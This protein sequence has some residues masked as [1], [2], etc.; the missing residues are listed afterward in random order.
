MKLFRI[1]TNILF[2]FSLLFILQACGSGGG[3]STSGSLTLAV[4]KSKVNCGDVVVATVTLASSISTMPVNG[5]KV[6]V[7]SSDESAISSTVG[8]TNMSGVANIVLPVKWFASDKVVTL[9]AGADGVTQSTYQP[10]VAF[11]PKL[12]VSIPEKPNG[13]PF[14]AG[15]LG[16]IIT[17][18]YTMSFKHNTDISG[19]ASPITGQS[20]NLYIDSI[21]NKDDFTEVIF[22][23]V[24]G[25]QIIAPPGFLTSVTDSTGTAQIPM[26]IILTVPKKVG[27]SNYVTLN[28]RAVTTYNG[29][30]FTT[31]GSSQYT[32]TAE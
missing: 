4:D 23:P 10:V 2:I 11:A 24:Q 9:V 32:A 7:M 16:K 20:I 22:N 15:A 13:T 6:R 8:T 28:Y 18:G 26:S 1:F 27:A 29:V 19:T 17:A 25:S 12:L 3:D 5:V 14:P 30:T 21:T 31:T